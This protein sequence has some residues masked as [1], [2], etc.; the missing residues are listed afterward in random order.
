MI[1][2][3][4]PSQIESL[5]SKQLVML[6]NKLLHAEAQLAGIS[7]SGISV[8]L[9]ITVSDGGEDARIAWP[10]GLE[11][12]DYL[13]SRFCIFQS[14][15][16][17]LGPAGWKREIW[18]KNSQMKDAT[19]QLNEAVKKVISERG[20][21][22]GFTSATVIGVKYDRRIDGIKQG[23]Q[24]AGA[25]PNQL[26]KIDI[27]DANKIA[28]WA[29]R[30]PA[31]AVWLNESQSGLDFR[32]IQTIASWGKKTDISS[33]Q[34]VDDKKERFYLGGEDIIGQAE[35]ESPAK[36]VL[37]FQQIKERITDYLANSRMAVRIIGPSG[38]GKTRF[39][40][41]VFRDETTLAKI[42]LSTS[43]IYCDFRD[44]GQSILQIAQS[45]SESGSSAL[46]VIDECPRET[47]QQLCEI[48]AR[49][50]SKIRVLT[51][52]IDDRP[53]ITPA[54]KHDH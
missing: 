27:Y 46:M 31:V 38:V 40:Y 8:P 11:K 33:I 4:N 9:Q 43:A 35:R 28:E 20:A 5:D 21:Y 41:E 2:E 12:T 13:P 22:I 36:N 14:K 44:I 49:A 47:A 54:I 17:T 39:I 10:G 15:A 16:T 24:E 52:G 32:S 53:I 30:H 19:R 50:D 3:I 51:I 29:S 48:A 25:D 37:P 6:L 1:F 7:L 26:T 42:S 45:L 34:H 23:I 18:T